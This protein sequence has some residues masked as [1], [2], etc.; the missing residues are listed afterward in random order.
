MKLELHHHNHHRRAR[1]LYLAAVG[2]IALDELLERL[3]VHL[4]RDTPR[5]GEHERDITRE[6]Y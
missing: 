4:G 5:I 2:D 6:V 3:A 1:A